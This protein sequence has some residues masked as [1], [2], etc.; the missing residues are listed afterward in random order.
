MKILSGIKRFMTSLYARLTS[1]DPVETL[2]RETPR[3]S[4]TVNVVTRWLHFFLPLS[5]IFRKNTDRKKSKI[6]NLKSLCI[7]FGE[8]IIGV[9]TRSRGDYPGLIY[10][11]PSGNG[12]RCPNSR[13]NHPGI[14]G[15]SP[16]FF[17][18]TGLHKSPPG[19]GKPWLTIT[20]GQYETQNH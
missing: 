19:C 15:T 14:V 6:I 10:A 1:R 12:G 5:F 17:T 13:G 2:P 18:L 20:L 8:W 4:R 9:I 7:P 16:N 11:S 3:K